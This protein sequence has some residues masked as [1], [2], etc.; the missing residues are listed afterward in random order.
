[1]LEL[2]L[3]CAPDVHPVTA[4]AI[5]QQESGGNPWAIYDNTGKQSYRPKSASEAAEIAQ[6]LVSQGHSIDIGLAQINSRNLPR[7][8][9]TVEQVLDPCMNLQASQTILKEGYR[10]SGGSLTGALSAYNTGKVDSV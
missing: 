8:K 5:V 7:L 2:L 6:R 9:L 3:T 4:A 10:R 1:M